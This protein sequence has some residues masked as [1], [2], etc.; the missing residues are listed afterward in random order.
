MYGMH[1]DNGAHLHCGPGPLLLG[2]NTLDGNDVYHQHDEDLGDIQ[3]TMLVGPIGGWPLQRSRMEAS[4][5][6][7]K[8]LCGAVERVD[9][10]TVNKGFIL[11]V[12][13]DGRRDA[14]GFDAD[15]WPD[16]ADEIWQKD[17]HSQF[18]RSRNFVRMPVLC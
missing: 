12:E 8:T 9:A 18:E 16:M 7:Q 15:D 3:E 14:R 6:G 4:G 13:K 5:H 1:S 17:V 2:A 11:N 10:H